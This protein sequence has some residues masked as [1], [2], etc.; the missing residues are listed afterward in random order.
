MVRSI[1]LG[2]ILLTGFIL[3]P[4]ALATR[5]YAFAELF[6]SKGE[7][8]AIYAVAFSPDGKTMASGGDQNNIIVWNCGCPIIEIGIYNLLS[9]YTL[10]PFDAELKGHSG[11]ITKLSYSNDGSRLA[12]ASTDKTVRIWSTTT[13]NTLKTYITLKILQGHTGEVTGVAFNQSGSKII[14]TSNDKSAII[15]DVESGKQLATLKGHNDS[16][17]DAIFHPTNGTILTTSLDNKTIVWN[18][19]TYEKLKILSGHQAGVRAIAF[20]PND[21]DFTTVSDD[22]TAIIWDANTYEYIGK[23]IGHNNSLLS[24]A[25]SG[26]GERIITGSSDSTAIIW[27]SKTRKRLWILNN[28][29][30]VYSVAANSNGSQ[31]LIAGAD[32]RVLFWE[33]SIYKEGNGY[34]F[35]KVSQPVDPD[36]PFNGNPLTAKSPPI[37]PSL[38]TSPPSVIILPPSSVA[39]SPP[40]PPPSVATLPPSVTISQPALSKGHLYFIGIS[41]SNFNGLT[42][43][44]F[45]NADVNAI[46][47]AVSQQYQ[48]FNT[49]PYSSMIFS[50]KNSTLKN[51]SD[52]LDEIQGKAQEKDT[53]ILSISSHGIYT[54]NSKY[55]VVLN[56]GSKN[57]GDLEK[58]GLS[59]AKIQAFVNGSKAS[60]LVLLDTCQA[61]VINSKGENTEGS[62]SP[63][64]FLKGFDQGSRGGGNKAILT[65]ASGSNLSYESGKIQHGVFTQAII[66]ALTG[67]E[68][69]F[70][71]ND[72]SRRKI[73]I[74]NFGTISNTQLAEYVLSRVPKLTQDLGSPPQTPSYH[75]IGEPFIIASYP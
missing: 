72:F 32:G 52:Y 60:V 34:N 1:I 38:V 56:N 41:A 4:L 70:N 51:I 28:L 66:E 2:I 62:S 19:L 35:Y 31:F 59:G 75:Q 58:N 16:V 50:G 21:K 46:G 39:T 7:S 65:A 55:Y 43:L 8:K 45:T 29:D 18:A 73:T 30:Y 24:V 49:N 67:E 6:Q 25:Y 68:F 17:T 47:A 3:L 71:N 37:T 26:D 14:T 20:N 33:D 64:E 27:D 54:I 11:K 13:Y 69:V 44:N 12:S 40:P 57:V 61:G 9:R 53:I 63:D 5:N 15:W 36:E 74:G 23:L 42:T 22:K 10:R 48:V